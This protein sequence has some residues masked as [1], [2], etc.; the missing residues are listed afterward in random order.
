L[1]GRGG[2]DGELEIRQAAEELGD[3]GGRR[4]GGR[5]EE[6]AGAGDE[7]VGVVGRRRGPGSAVGR[8]GGSEGGRGGAGA[9]GGRGAEDRAELVEPADAA[10]VEGQRREEPRRGGG[11]QRGRQRGEDAGV[12]RGG[13]EHRRE[14][15][16]VS[17]SAGPAACARE[18]AHVVV[19]RRAHGALDGGEARGRGHGGG[20]REQQLGGQE[21]RRRLVQQQDVVVVVVVRL[22]AALLPLLRR[23]GSR[24]R[25]GLHDRHEL[26]GLGVDDLG[27]RVVD[28]HGRPRRGLL[29]LLVVPPRLR[30]LRRGRG[31]ESPRRR[32]LPDGVRLHPDVE[33]GRARAL[34]LPPRR[35]RPPPRRR[36]RV[37]PGVP[38]ELLRP[39]CGG[40]V[41]RRRQ[42]VEERGSGVGPGAGVV[43]HEAR[44]AGAE[45]QR[46]EREL[47]WVLGGRVSSAKAGR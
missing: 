11:R 35:G 42:A 2:G 10:G 7:R 18:D 36:R 15:A 25:E 5:G 30:P 23:A 20:R 17:V 33:P 12:A 31:S 32:G 1:D 16:V 40:G 14:R 34:Q 21:R 39:G 26:A 22:A 38:G 4:H 8:G 27:R 44:A 29:L 3:G 41:L 6:V 37:H 43:Q 28:D 9:G 47:A 45:A 24:A 46:E 19:R 13:A